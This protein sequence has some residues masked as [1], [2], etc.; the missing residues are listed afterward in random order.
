M[1]INKKIQGVLFLV[2]GL[3][4]TLFSIYL[5]NSSSV[6]SIRNSTKDFRIEIYLLLL[7]S[8]LLSYSGY[9]TL[10]KEHKRDAYSPSDIL[11]D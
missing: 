2:I 9:L 6:Y 11:D 10:K 4:T 3:T 5:L 1:R 7:F 8:I